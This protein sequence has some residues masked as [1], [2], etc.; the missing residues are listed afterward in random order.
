MKLQII[1]TSIHECEDKMEPK[2]V[3]SFTP[4]QAALILEE[5]PETPYYDSVNQMRNLL[6]RALELHPAND[7]D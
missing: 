2:F 5:T 3:L 7:E 1:T 4:E 6:T